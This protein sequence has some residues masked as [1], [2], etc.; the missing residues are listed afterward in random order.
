MKIGVIYIATG[1]Y[2]QFWDE[3]YPTCN[4]Y[5]CADA[6]KTFELFTDSDL[7]LS[8]QLYNVRS[9]RIEDR[10]F[11]VNVSAKSELIC[12]I[13]TEL[14]QYDYVFY[15]NGNFKFLKPI[16]TSE[17]IPNGLHRYLT[18]LSFDAYESF[19][20]SQLP[21]DRNPNS[22]AYIPYGEGRKY[23]QGGF[24]GG[25]PQAVLMFSE[26]SKNAI[27]RDLE[28]KIVAKHHDES[29]LNRYLVSKSPRTIN[30]KYAYYPHS[31]YKGSYKAILIDKSQYLSAKGV[32]FLK[33]SYDSSLSFL[34]NDQLRALPMRI[35]SFS[36]G[37]GNQLFQYSFFEYIRSKSG[38]FA[39]CYF[40]TNYYNCQECHNGFELSRFF[41]IDS[42]AHL[43]FDL[44][45]K[46]NLVNPRYRFVYNEYRNSVFQDIQLAEAPIIIYQGYWQCIQYI[47]HN[48][49][50]IRDLFSFDRSS[51]SENS[52]V[53]LEQIHACNSVSIHVRRG[54]YLTSKNEF[55]YGDICGIEYYREAMSRM[56]SLLEYMPTFFVFTDDKAWVA[57]QELF[58]DAILVDCNSVENSWE[59]LCLMTECKHH[60][61]ANSSFSWWGAWLSRYPQKS[62]IAPEYWYNGIDAPDL[63][64]VDWIK[65]PIHKRW[66]PSYIVVANQLMHLHAI[67]ALGLNNGKM[68]L[69]VSFYHYA[70]E[71]GKPFFEEIADGLLS[72]VCSGVSPCLPTSF[73]SGLTG[74][75]WAIGELIREG[76]VGGDANDV[77]VYMDLW[78]IN[79]VNQPWGAEVDIY[80]LGYY[81]VYRLLLNKEDKSSVEIYDKLNDAVKCLLCKLLDIQNV[82]QI[83][84]AILLLNHMYRQNVYHDEINTLLVRFISQS[85]NDFLMFNELSKSKGI[86][87]I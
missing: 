3:F 62:V 30:E 65:I 37:L 28:R 63:L 78:V 83:K 23:Y 81:L 45:Q 59:D 38:A 35:V 71:V 50:R 11:I 39:N 36:G 66:T 56:F 10:G 29:Y 47:Q 77:L 69:A 9:H 8:A 74:I 24:Y 25:K 61:I 84:E 46:I 40:D 15:L 16:Y 55:L 33:E 22:S 60:I 26:W 7:L 82:H 49:Q 21:Y 72:D 6:E 57:E 41:N 73:S 31:S 32:P 12:S 87:K 20:P 70:R 5:F 67:K 13:A 76:F 51:L 34:L 48:E 75:G 27:R 43:S 2:A 53:F 80:G 18:V 79:K 85:S 68:G 14:V 44:E 64:P 4:S 58:R 52:T 1:V 17:I 86:Y 54:D 19:L 42:M